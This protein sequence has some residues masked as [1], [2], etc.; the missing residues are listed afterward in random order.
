MRRTHALV[1][2][3]A[4]ALAAC[5]GAPAAA[6]SS[7]VAEPPSTRPPPT[8]PAPSVGFA[9]DHVDL[10][11]L[12]ALAS[13][14]EVVLVVDPVHAGSAM[15]I[16]ARDR[17]DRL[18]ETVDVAAGV[19]AANQR[20]ASLHVLH[21]FVAMR[22]IVVE[23]SHDNEDQHWAS[24]DNLDVEWRDHHVSVFRHNDT[25][26]LVV[27]DGTAWLAPDQGDCHHPAYLRDVFHAVHH[28]VLI[29]AI[30]YR[31]SAACPAPPDTLHVVTWYPR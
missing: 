12:P 1:I 13:A 18:L 20:L 3:P 22:P 21:D 16:E 19:D 30:G 17:D 6:P 4:L 15:R 23:P 5:G 24:G 26:P 29:V 28:D 2:Q 14:D 25:V 11:V 10:R 27:R 8:T 7:R 9:A 31:G